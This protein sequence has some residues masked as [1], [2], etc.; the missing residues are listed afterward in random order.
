MSDDAGNNSLEQGANSAAH[1]AQYRFQKGDVRINR[2]GRPKSAAFREKCR[3]GADKAAQRLMALVESGALDADPDQLIRAIEVLGD[4]GG[5]LTVDK[6]AAAQVSMSRVALEAA[7]APGM[8]D[9]LRGK[10]M[11]ETTLQAREL[12]GETLEGEG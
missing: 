4:R 8:T 9:E 5:Y 7:G 12:F 1:L 11:D 10:V 6:I 2:A 3:N